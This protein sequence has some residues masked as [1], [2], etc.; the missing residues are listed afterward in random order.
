MSHRLRLDESAGADDLFAL[1]LNRY[2]DATRDGE[3]I[4]IS[5]TTRFAPAP[6]GSEWEIHTPKQREQDFAPALADGYGLNRAFADGI[7]VG[8]ER[9]VLEFLLGAVRRIGGVLITDSHFELSPHQFMLPDLRVVA[10]YELRPEQCL[11]IVR[12]IVK[13][14][15]IEG[16]P[17]GAPYAI[18][19][20]IFPDADLE[21]RVLE[22]DHEIPAIAHVQWVKDGAAV[23]HVLFQPHD[24]DIAVADTPDPAQVKKWREAYLGCSAIAK[25]LHDVTGGFILDI[26]G[27]LVNPDDLF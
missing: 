22:L 17:D 27:F 8:E 20:P 25:S 19:L 15:R 2:P 5:D 9:E 24:E 13:E 10:P 7:P 14:A 23:Y 12:E 3:A 11:E 16:E 1:V 4:R 6:H 21:V 18:T 26:E